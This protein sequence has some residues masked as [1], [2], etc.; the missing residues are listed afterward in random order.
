[1]TL[2]PRAPLL[3]P[4]ILEA[5]WEGPDGPG[6]LG[7]VAQLAEA[8]AFSW[9]PQWVLGPEALEQWGQG[10]L[11]GKGNSDWL[12]SVC[13]SGWFVFHDPVTEAC[14]GV[15]KMKTLLVWRLLGWRVPA[16]GVRR[17]RTGWRCLRD[18]SNHLLHHPVPWVHLCTQFSHQP[19]R[20]PLTGGETKALRVSV[21][22]PEPRRPGFRAKGLL[23]EARHLLAGFQHRN[24]GSEDWEPARP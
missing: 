23:L 8:V 14:L 4:S 10:H 5:W 7:K 11:V 9:W 18:R 15:G 2:A 13:C 22:P 12:T 3:K 19:P 21:P 1:M 16:R 24:L 20:L 6:A 17:T